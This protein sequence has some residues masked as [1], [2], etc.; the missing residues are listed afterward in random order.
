MNKANQDSEYSQII[1]ELSEYVCVSRIIDLKEKDQRALLIAPYSSR[2]RMHKNEDKI[3]NASDIRVLHCLMYL[4]KENNSWLLSQN[5]VVSTFNCRD[6]ALNQV[7]SILEE[8]WI[9]NNVSGA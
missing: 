8:Y 4:W 3:H 1:V 5:R 2:G 9:K 6:K 7:K